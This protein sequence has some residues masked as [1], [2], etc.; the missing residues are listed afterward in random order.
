[1]SSVSR[2]PH[3]FGYVQDSVPDIATDL[4]FYSSSNF[5]GTRVDGYNANR[6]I[7]TKKAIR[8]LKDVQTELKEFNLGIKI[9]DAY[10]PVKG[11]RYLVTWIENPDNVGLSHIFFPKISRE[12][13]ISRGY[14][15]KKS[16][17]SRGSALDITLISLDDNMEIDMGSI[18]GLFDEISR[19]RYPNLS[20]QQR[21][22]RLLLYQVMKNN[23]FESYE[24]EWWHY[25]LLD[26]PFPDQYFDFDIK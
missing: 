18:C 5:T 2:L 9:I 26:E 6:A 21:A 23:G 20:S 25:Q 17:H 1:M 12:E 3:G 15:A 11:T 22:N 13:I 7:L 16:G 14:L 4:I 24:K 8:S 19:L 10:K